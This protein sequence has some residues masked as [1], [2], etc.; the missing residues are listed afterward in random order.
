LSS[1]T[2]ERL[3]RDRK[4]TLN[5]VLSVSPDS[6]NNNELSISLDSLVNQTDFIE[7]GTLLRMFEVDI[8][9]E[10]LETIKN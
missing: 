2:D 8:L 4:E 5:T 6:Y 3:D 1:K 7:L 10:C 9:D